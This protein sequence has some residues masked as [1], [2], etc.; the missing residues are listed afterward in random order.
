MSQNLTAQHAASLSRIAAGIDVL[1]ARVKVDDQVLTV[2]AHQVGRALQ[3][4]HGTPVPGLQVAANIEYLAMPAAEF[5][6]LPD[7]Q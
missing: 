5:A 1:A 7:W 6:A 4:L 3:I 2:A